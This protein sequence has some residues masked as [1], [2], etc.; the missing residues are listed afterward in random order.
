MRIRLIAVLSVLGCAAII[1][2]AVY[3]LA[4]DSNESDREAERAWREYAAR[5][6][7]LSFK[8]EYEYSHYDD[9]IGLLTWYQASD[10]RVRLDYAYVDEEGATLQRVYIRSG[11]IEQSCREP[12]VCANGNELFGDAAGGLELAF[13]YPLFTA[14]SPPPDDSRRHESRYR[15]SE[16]SEEIRGIEAEC[17]AVTVP[18]Q[19]T[20]PYWEM[21]FTDDAV[22]VRLRTGDADT[23]FMLE[24]LSVERSVADS[25]FTPPYPLEP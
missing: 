15:V 19:D 1:A 2:V 21:C 10:H 25:V 9:R 12:G 14:A 8:A 16:S 17:F 7:E 18:E 20:D 22:P 11:D 23:E 6:Q 13:F 5:S 3:M 4:R 24:A